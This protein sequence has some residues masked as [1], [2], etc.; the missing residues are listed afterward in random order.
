[1][2]TRA[3]VPFWK[4]WLS[5]LTEVHIESASSSYNPHLYVSMV[6]GRYMLSTDKA[7]YSYGDRYYN[8]GHVFDRMNLSGK[9]DVLI[10]GFGLGSIPILLEKKY[11]HMQIT[12]VEID[13]EVIYLAS[14]YVI[15]TLKS[16]INLVQADAESFIDIGNKKYD[17]IAMDVFESDYIPHRF[18]SE[19]FLGKLK[20]SLTSEGILLYNRLAY[21]DADL[22]NTDQFYNGPFMRQFPDG[23]QVGVKGN[24][25][26]VN[27]RKFLDS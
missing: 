26:L 14:K 10:L 11:S 22:E 19:S 23:M 3:M 5:Y 16:E 12:G 1:M 9:K 7:I 21:T 18:E 25:M 13:E 20:A 6:S 2:S 17:L 24:R 4:R 15:P 27:S 8:F